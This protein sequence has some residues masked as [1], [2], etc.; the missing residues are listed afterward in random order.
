MGDTVAE[1]DA[2]VADVEAFTGVIEQFVPQSTFFL[3]FLPLVQ[4]ILGSVQTVAKNPQAA[5]PAATPPA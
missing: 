5:A 2:I 3:N 1:V 4:Q